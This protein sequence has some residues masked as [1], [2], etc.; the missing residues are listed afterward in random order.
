M[1]SRLTHLVGSAVAIVA[2]AGLVAATATASPTAP[3]PGYLPGKWQVT[4]TI[5]GS[6]SDGP[7]TTVFGGKLRFTLNVARNLSVGGA[8]TWAMTMK[9]TGPVGSTMN[10][11]AAVTLSGT[12]VDVRFAGQQRVTGTVSDGTLS[13]PIR[14]TRPLTGRLVIKR[15]GQCRVT[16]TS[17]MGGGV[18]LAWTALLAGSG[19]CRA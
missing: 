18:T 11:T 10:G 5:S 16:G 7:M 17:P 12:S 19:T 8:G 15:A 1:F 6:S 3:T 4:G 13:T 14:M 2:L 9:G